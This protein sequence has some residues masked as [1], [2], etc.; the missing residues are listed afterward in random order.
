MQLADM[1]E[2]WARTI[3]TLPADEQFGL[4]RELHVPEVVKQAI[5]RTARKNLEMNG[6]MTPD[7]RVRFA[8]KVMLT[9]TA[10]KAANARNRER[11]RDEM[12]S[13]VDV[14]GERV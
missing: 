5:L 9:L 14:D 4:W 1:K 2:L 10:Q 8:S 7:H 12:E 3:D 13:L 6:T 11:L